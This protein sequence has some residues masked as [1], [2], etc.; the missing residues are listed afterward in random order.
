MRPR[1]AHRWVKR[2]R[3]IL[4]ILLGAF[5][6]VVRYVPGWGYVLSA[7]EKA[8]QLLHEFDV[9]L[10]RR[11]RAVKPKKPHGSADPAT[12]CHVAAV[13]TELLG[14][15]PNIVAHMAVTRYDDGKPRQVGWV[16]LKTVGVTWVLEAK[17]PDSGCRLT[18]VAGTLDDALVTLDALL[19][20]DDAPWIA[21]Q[22]AQKG[23][24]G[25]K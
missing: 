17:D 6:I 4:R 16:M 3:H 11:K 2:V 25:K 19:G 1:R 21:D 9:T 15:C 20:A 7:V 8:G 14:Q 5:T 18:A 24:K 23:G 13:E 22:W 10:S 12:P